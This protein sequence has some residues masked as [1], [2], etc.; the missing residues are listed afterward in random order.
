MK[1]RLLKWELQKLFQIRGIWGLL[2][3]MLL[4]NIF[5]SSPKRLAASEW[6]EIRDIQSAVEA[7]NLKTIGN[8]LD[9]ASLLPEK[10]VEQAE[11]HA[12][13][14]RK[15]F[16]LG[17]ETVTISG[18][19]FM[20]LCRVLV[21][22]GMIIGLM[23]VLFFYGVEQTEHMEQMIYSARAGRKIILVKLCA[24]TLITVAAYLLLCVCSLLIF[25]CR[26]DVPDY[27]HAEMSNPYHGYSLSGSF[28]PYNTY[29]NMTVWQYLLAVLALGAF[30]SLVVML[31][32]YACMLLIRN[33][34]AGALVLAGFFMTDGVAY[35][36]ISSDTFERIW[37]W[38]IVPEVMVLPG[39]FTDMAGT[40]C[41]KWQETAAAAVNAGLVL[42]LWLISYSIFLKRDIT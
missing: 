13:Q 9:T 31:A 4:L 38:T 12:E 18:V 35:G 17:E 20:V 26:W 32:G 22:E 11:L 15:S 6:R 24:C 30:L 34:Y 7:Y 16:A 25:I 37:R 40:V 2:L 1:V 8:V 3:L 10:L 42:L 29:V 19:L 27:F 33:I 14:S 21:G 23:T 39:W 5:F 36:L 41:C 28:V